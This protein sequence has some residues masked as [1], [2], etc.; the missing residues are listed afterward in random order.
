MKQLMHALILRNMEENP[1]VSRATTVFDD[2]DSIERLFDILKNI[3]KTV[4][5]K[6]SRPD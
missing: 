1:T 6:A 3:N 4:D 2:F 5:V